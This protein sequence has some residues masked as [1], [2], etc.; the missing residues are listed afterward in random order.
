MHLRE[1]TLCI[2]LKLRSAA[3]ILEA[4][5]ELK[6]PRNCLVFKAVFVKLHYFYVSM[7]SNWNDSKPAACFQI[8][9][10]KNQATPISEARLKDGINCFVQCVVNKKIS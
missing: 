3:S 6:S 4:T 10:L 9:S 2:A 7:R 1:A 5:P 8:T